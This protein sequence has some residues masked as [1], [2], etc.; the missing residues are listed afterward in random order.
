MDLSYEKKERKTEIYQMYQ[1]IF[2]D[3][4]EFA[5]YYFE[6]IYPG[7]RVLTAQEHGEIRE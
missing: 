2:E 6:E 5:R 4:E 7:N 3:P 1:K